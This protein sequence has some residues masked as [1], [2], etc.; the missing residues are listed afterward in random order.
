MFVGN[1]ARNQEMNIRIN[2]TYSTHYFTPAPVAASPSAIPLEALEGDIFGSISVDR[3]SLPEGDYTFIV[4][5]GR[6]NGSVGGWSHLNIYN[7]TILSNIKAFTRIGFSQVLSGDVAA[8][9]FSLTLDGTEEIEF[10]V[11]ADDTPGFIYYRD[12]TV[13]K[14]R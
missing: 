7:H 1:V 8:K 2:A 9:R 10:R 3:L 14:T 12:I 13:I 4:P 6:S 11:Y 5:S